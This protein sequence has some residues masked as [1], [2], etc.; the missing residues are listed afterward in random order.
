MSKAEFAIQECSACGFAVT[1][2]RPANEDLGSYYESDEYISHSNTSK[3]LV[4]KAYQLVR[5]YT[6]KKKIRLL[7]EQLSGAKGDLLDI[8]C[9]TGE[10][11]N[12]CQLAGWQVTGIEPST[13]ARAAAI[14][15]YKLKVLDE[16]ALTRL[17]ENGYLAIS[18]WHV[19]EHVP[20]LQERMQTLKRLLKPG[21]VLVIAVPNRQSGDAR[22][23]KE[24]WAAYD[25]PRHLWH[26]RPSDIRSLANQNGFTVDQILPM[27]FDAYYVSMLS[28]KYKTGT[29]NYL[30]AIWRAWQSNRNAETEKWSSQIYI[31]KHKH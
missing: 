31:L 25:V 15:N 17:P 14:Q 5:T 19:L 9:G 21:G 11:L 6:L 2:P 4:S 26:F 8:G 23:Y 29:P 3:G 13:S 10:F 20:D 7:D 12:A 16:L 30:T 28:E 1:N 27:V 18:L 22:H 24:H